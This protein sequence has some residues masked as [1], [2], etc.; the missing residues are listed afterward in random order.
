MQ[1]EISLRGA[2]H[3]FW[4][5]GHNDAITN[6]DELFSSTL[7]LH[8]FHSMV[9]ASK[10][11]VTD[12]GDRIRLPGLGGT[13]E[14][15]GMYCL[16]RMC[17]TRWCG[18]T[19]ILET[20][21]YTQCT[22]ARDRIYALHGVRS[23]DNNDKVR[24]LPVPDYTKEV[25]FVYRHYAT[26]LIQN[27]YA[28]SVIRA[29]GLSRHSIAL[30]S[31]CPDWSASPQFDPQN[32]G[33]RLTAIG[34]DTWPEFKRLVN[35]H[36]PP[37]RDRFMRAISGGTDNNIEYLDR[38]V[39]VYG[40]VFDTVRELGPK[41][42]I[43]NVNTSR[44]LEWTDRAR[45]LVKSFQLLQ[46]TGAA[47]DDAT[48]YEVFCRMLMFAEA[49]QSVPPPTSAQFRTA[50]GVSPPEGP[51][52]E[53]AAA[54]DASHGHFREA[55]ADDPREA[56]LADDFQTVVAQVIQDRRVCVTERG[57]IGLVPE[58]TM[59]G[60]RVCQFR[61]AGSPAILREVAHGFHDNG[62][63]KDYSPIFLHGF[64]ENSQERLFRKT[65]G[66]TQGTFLLIGNAYLLEMMNG[67]ALTYRL[68][69]PG[70]IVLI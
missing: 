21:R 7:A 62:K 17:R 2:K 25:N 20:F 50:F 28:L 53:C 64:S 54:W 3:A 5:Y 63:S 37:T 39:N 38:H 13:P 48:R 70:W 61:G 22:D 67:E 49:L 18:F 11:R 57:Y 1:Q 15:F 4:S 10:T 52:E 40:C 16:H 46:R 45:W 68:S 47:S 27:V 35:S 6:L 24:D 44:K 51:L 26:H 55:T 42:K 30:P 58:M 33:P 29:A 23:Q 19:E 41:P 14:D 34:W 59:P 9:Q 32:L 60:D 66:N 36:K 43:A 69:Q 31:W 56:R 8:V 65:A 12:H